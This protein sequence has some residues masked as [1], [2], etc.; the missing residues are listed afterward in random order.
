MLT[1]T[2]DAPEQLQGSSS[3]LSH[4]WNI[5]TQHILIYRTKFCCKRGKLHVS[6]H[7]CKKLCNVFN[8]IRK[9]LVF[10]I[11][12]ITAVYKKNMLLCV[13]SQMT[14]QLQKYRKYRLSFSWK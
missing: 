1:L 4:T 3:Q 8:K 9:N 5:Y 11:F 10:F 6:I 13:V 14:I 12:F 2:E 7:V